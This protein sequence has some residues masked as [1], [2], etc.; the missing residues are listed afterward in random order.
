MKFTILVCLIIQ[1]GASEAAAL[2][3]KL[4][5]FRGLECS[6]D[7]SLAF[8]IVTFY[9]KKQHSVT[10]IDF[11]D[12]PVLSSLKCRNS[13]L[14]VYQFDNWSKVNLGERIHD[15]GLSAYSITRGFL[16][17]SGFKDIIL[18]LPM[19]A[20][21]NPQGKLLLSLD[22]GS[23]EEAKELLEISYHNHSMLDVA[24][25]LYFSEYDKG[26]Y[27]GMN[28][29][30][31]LYNPFT[32]DVTIKP[33]EF[34]CFNFTKSA[35]PFNDM[36]KFIKNRVRNLNQHPLRIDIFEEVM[37]SKAVRNANG[38]ITNYIY[39]DGDT[40]TYLSR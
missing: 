19:V 6:M 39:P 31:C 13:N 23:F 3:K 38:M 5:P 40:V 12:N 24:V 7:V 9:F 32:S 20:E 36:Y 15:S 10:V 16:I 28:T 22:F 18:L 17:K 33:R 34:R 35:A 2:N 26:E 21:F 29:S 4:L 8:D 25:I 37:L 14:P 27:T 11:S 30:V 1:L